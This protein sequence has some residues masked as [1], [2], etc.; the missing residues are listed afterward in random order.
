[1]H[2]LILKPSFVLCNVS[3]GLHNF[4]SS[5]YTASILATF[6][7]KM[8]C[9]TMLWFKFINCGKT[10]RD[11]FLPCFIAV[12]IEDFKPYISSSTP[13]AALTTFGTLDAKF[14]GLISF[15]SCFID[16]TS[17]PHFSNMCN[18]YRKRIDYNTQ[19]SNVN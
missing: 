5:F 2:V 14:M 4:D 15:D 8:Q 18:K 3:I 9:F 16:N 7:T 1:M 11:A 10:E 13:I 12:N 19:H 6:S 17:K